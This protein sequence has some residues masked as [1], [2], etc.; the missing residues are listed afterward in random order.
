MMMSYKL[1]PL[2]EV[3]IDEHDR[4]CEIAC[5]INEAMQNY[6]KPDD[7]PLGVSIIDYA[8]NKLLNEIKSKGC[9]K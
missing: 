1:T 4:W 5:D 8:L 6:G 3:Y 7:L 9:A 2:Q